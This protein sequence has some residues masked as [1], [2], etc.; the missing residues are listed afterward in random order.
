MSLA[1]V[2]Y[3]ILHL[4][5]KDKSIHMMGNARESKKQNKLQRME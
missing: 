5:C 1:L 2:E 4:I 3:R